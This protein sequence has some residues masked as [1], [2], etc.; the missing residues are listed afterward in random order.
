MDYTEF[1]TTT[2]D[3]ILLMKMVLYKH[4]LMYGNGRNLKKKLLKLH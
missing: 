3:E 4:K 2:Q 1:D